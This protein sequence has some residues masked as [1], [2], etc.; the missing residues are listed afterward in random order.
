MPGIGELLLD[1]SRERARIDAA[2][3]AARTGTGS[4][5]VIE[6]EPGIG[7]TALLQ[8]ARESAAAAGLGVLQ[9]CGVELEAEFAFGVV[10]QC[11]EPAIRAADRAERTRLFS[12]AAALAEPLL[13]DL[14]GTDPQA[15]FGALHGLYWLLANLCESRPLLIAIDDAHW[16]D[17]ASLRYFAYLVR[18]V[19]SLPLALM[20][21]TRPT[22]EQE[23]SSALSGLLADPGSQLLMPAALSE[24][25]VAQLLGYEAE[26]G[27]SRACHDATGGNPFLLDQLIR[28]LREQG[29]PFTAA[30][31]ERVQTVALPQVARA[32]RARLAR[33]EPEAA[34][35]AR[36]LAVLGDHAA[37]EWASELAGITTAA[38]ARAAEGLT[39]VG[40]VDF[41]RVLRF[42][43]PLL[44]AAVDTS[45]TP[46]ERD[47]AHRKAASLL[48]ARDA[49][50]EQIAVHVLIATPTGSA[51]D[52]RTLRDAAARAAQR[53]A[54]A[55]AVPFLRRT[56][57][58]AL[59]SE[60][61]VDVL[62]DLGDAERAAGKLPDAAEHLREAVRL[63]DD[64]IIRA[65][66]LVELGRTIGP[67][68][69][70]HRELLALL[71]GT[72][73]G[74][75]TLELDRDLELRLKG[76]FLTAAFTAGSGDQPRVREIAA[77]LAQLPGDTPVESIALCGV[78]ESMVQRGLLV[79]SIAF[80]AAGIGS[81]AER[82]AYHADELLAA[83][84]RD[85]RAH[86]LLLALRWTDHLDAAERVTDQWTEIA[87]RQGSEEA[88]AAARVHSSHLNRMRGRLRQAEADAE[89]ATAATPPHGVNYVM[90]CVALTDCLI[91]K[92]D[93]DAAQA[94][95]NAIGFG[96]Q[97]PP[98][99]PYGGVLGIRA[100][101]RC[102]LGRHAAALADYDALTRRPGPRNGG[103]ITTIL[104]A[105]ESHHALGHQDVVKTELDQAL[106]LAQQWGT[107]SAIGSVMRVRGRLAGDPAHAIEDL[108]TAIEYLQRSPRRLVYARALT[109]LGSA[110]RRAGRR[111][112]A[113]E[114]LR[115]GYDL[116]RE[117][118]AHG[119]AETA[120]L[121]L[122]A[123]G[124]RL[125]RERLTGAESLTASERRIAD[126]AAAGASN[127]E[128]AQALF[129][130]VKT[131][132]M[133]LTHAYRKLDITGRAALP[134]ALADPAAQPA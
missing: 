32:M 49:P 92:G 108:R 69:A 95:C 25:A 127:A 116:A 86:G 52:A 19:D 121:E 26:D 82:A 98:F 43:H 118:G 1:R 91:S 55:S 58:E 75:S 72:L 56:L 50:P 88:F 106:T 71:E 66:A 99:P 36:S 12:G 11:L 59:T 37:L 102:A 10:R 125:R 29:V 46:L 109:D 77:E 123:S 73:P 120:R 14:I 62:L 84:V 38:G 4:A 39:R 111:S 9:A 81:L 94:A 131:V 78:I 34:M 57:D 24:L 31:A 23:E 51:A 93:L 132:E 21:A 103:N 33:L 70:A 30:S 8:L 79:P 5:L 22:G 110:L 27:F 48:R 35:L 76:A 54:P 18:R 65:R 105:I 83:G 112:D 61:R 115:A 15:S 64:P 63:A 101:L 89:T 17:D 2:L 133:H 28:V 42:R 60:D 113:R 128:I 41:D 3:E 47:A 67:D 6:G 87:H 97:I 129:V 20:I 85:S 119:L 130:T 117:C 124:V 74:A 107:P 40:L 44:R 96:E 90:A 45:I 7:K 68:P 134:A 16:A 126:L 122:A 104:A 80:N 13:T 53:G 100:E 114:P